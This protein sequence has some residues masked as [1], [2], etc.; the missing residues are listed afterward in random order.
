MRVLL[1]ILLIICFL[2]VNV[3][4]SNVIS[5]HNI[6]SDNLTNKTSSSQFYIK[7]GNTSLL[8]LSVATDWKYYTTSDGLANDSVSVVA[9]DSLNNIM[10][11]KI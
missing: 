8:F 6:S 11:F 3:N 2:G 7:N 1:F 5:Y 9:T 10:K 4:A